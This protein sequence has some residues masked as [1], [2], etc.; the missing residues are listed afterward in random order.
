[1]FSVHF[2][3][4]FSASGWS[5]LLGCFTFF[6]LKKKI[7]KP[8]LTVCM[9]FFTLTIYGFLKNYRALSS[10]MYVMCCSNLETVAHLFLHFSS[11]SH[12]EIELLEFLVEIW[13]MPMELGAFL[14]FQVQ[15]LWQEEG[16]VFGSLWL[17]RNAQNFW[18]E[19]LLLD[20]LCTRIAFV[21]LMFFT[22]FCLALVLVVFCLRGMLLF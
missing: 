21:S 14:I 19:S 15:K 5:R 12:I 13:Y 6:F 22:M 9:I 16:K 2:V 1:M 10:G 4:F 11:A 17:K 7:I 20:L 18:G 3:Q 8:F